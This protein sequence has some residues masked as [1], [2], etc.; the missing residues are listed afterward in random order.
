MPSRKEDERVRRIELDLAIDHRLG[1][2]FPRE[3]REALWTVQQR[4]ERKRLQLG[5]RH[6]FRRAFTRTKARDA[7]RLAGYLADEYAEV[8]SQ[9]ELAR[10]FDLKAGEPPALPVDLEQLKK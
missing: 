3:R 2:N 10:F 8:L 6:L 4:V 5:L 1:R 7:Q 9:A